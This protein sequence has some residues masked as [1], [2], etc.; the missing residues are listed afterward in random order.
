MSNGEQ[1]ESQTDAA[2]AVGAEPTSKA[3]AASAAG[4]ASD[5]TTLAVMVAI[6]YL[7]IGLVVALSRLDPM[8]MYGMGSLTAFVGHLFGWPLVLLG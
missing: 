8:A 3:D 4:H 1:T 7:L 2:T 6:P 5:R